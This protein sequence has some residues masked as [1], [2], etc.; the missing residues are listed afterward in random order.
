M[1]RETIFALSTPPGTGAVAVIRLSGLRATAALEA[2]SGTLPA[3]RVTALRTIRHPGSSEMIDRA[4]VFWHQGPASFT[5]EDMVEFHTHGSPA[6]V[7]SLLSALGS[8][9]G[10]RLAEPGEFTRRAYLN[11]KLDLLAAE[12][13]ADLVRANT[14]RQQRQALFQ[15]SGVAGAVIR[16]WGSRLRRS[17]ALLE[18]SLDFADDAPDAVELAEGGFM[19]CVNVRQEILQQLGR[20]SSAERLR[21]GYR[22]VLCGPPN[23][24]KSSLFNRLVGD[25]AAIV[26]PVAGTTRDLLRADLD[27]GGLPVILFDSAGIRTTEDAIEAEGVRRALQAADG[28]DLVVWVSSPDGVHDHLPEFDSSPLWVWNK[29]DLGVAAPHGHLAV[30]CVSGDGLEAFRELLAARL[31]AETGWGEP[32]VVTRLRHRTL[33]ENAAV[34]LEGIGSA[35]EPPEVNAE[36]LRAC[37][38]AFDELMGKTTPEDILDVVF[39]EFC[40]GK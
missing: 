6:V 18:A 23:S 37:L 32:P 26:T 11:G 19:D 14:A 8:M 7:R 10:L 36:R 33:L 31:E 29:S 13:L 34:A 38:Q 16:D 15:A 3:P 35:G 4:M 9:K 20:A 27:V 12:G 17:L 40:I 22:V 39:R 24:G 1:N 28:S 21:S 25:E 5:G 2:L 30:S